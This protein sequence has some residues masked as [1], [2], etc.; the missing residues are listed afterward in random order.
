MH[1]RRVIVRDESL[2]YLD[3]WSLACRPL[4]YLQHD[5]CFIVEAVAAVLEAAYVGED[6]FSYLSGRRLAVAA[7]HVC[8]PFV[9]VHFV[10]R[11]Y[12]VEN[13]ERDEDHGVAGLRLDAKLVVFGIRKHAKRKALRA[14]EH[15]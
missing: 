7:E 13:A 10:L 5:D 15:P 1:G 9:A 12:R 14:N 3:P 2:T 4:A 6:G 11:V 8:Q